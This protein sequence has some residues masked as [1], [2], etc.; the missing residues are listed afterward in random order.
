MPNIFCT[1]RI[2][3]L[4]HVFYAESVHS[5]HYGHQIS[6]HLYVACASIEI[7][8]IPHPFWSPEIATGA[9]LVW[10]D[11]FFPKYFKVWLVSPIWTPVGLFAISNF[12]GSCLLT[13]KGQKSKVNVFLTD[14]IVLPCMK[15][16]DPC[17]LTLIG[18][19][20]SVQKFK[21]KLPIY[22]I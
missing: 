16:N 21:L 8:I 7:K 13:Y 19:V 14:W 12:V 5:G 6:D 1:Q 22:M 18:Q 17:P 10:R 15:E 9:T 11:D 2:L 20:R 3:Y 4:F